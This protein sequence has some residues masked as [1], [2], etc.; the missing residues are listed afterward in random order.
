MQD[1]DFSIFWRNDVHAQGLFYDLLARS[2]RHAYD[3]DF[4]MQLAAYR[5]A[6][7]DAAHADIFAAQYLLANGDAEAA[8]VCGERAYHRRQLAPI[9]W[10]T[11]AATYKAQGRYV[12]A[13]IMQGYLSSCFNVP[14][15]LNL[16]REVLTQDVLDRLSVAMGKPSYAPIALFRMTYDKNRGLSS[17]ATAFVGEFLPVSPMYPHY[18]VGVYTEQELHGG[19]A[20]MIA[21]T[22]NLDG[23]AAHVS[24]DFLFDLMRGSR[25]HGSAHI[26]L[27]P[28]QEVVLPL[29]GTGEST[30]EIRIRAD[31]ADGTALLSTATPSFFRLS[32]TTDFSSPH[33]FIVGTPIAIGHA[34]HRRRLVLNLLV[35]ALPWEIMGTDFAAHMPYTARFFTK[36]LTFRQQF[37]TA[38][39]T[40]PSLAAIETGMYAQHSGVF[41]DR[42][43]MTL[44]PEFVTL[45]ERM[46]S[47]GYATTNLRGDG[48]GVYNGVTRGYDRLIVTPYRL[49]A[50]E[51]AEQV[52]RYLEG[53]PDADHFIYLHTQDLHPWPNKNFSIPSAAQAQLSLADRI[54]AS[55]EG[56]P[57]PYLS[58]SALNQAG[59][60]QS[61]RSVDRALGMLFTYLEEH[62]PPDEYLVNLYSDHGVSIF[63]ED[64][65]IVSAALTHTAWMMRGAGVPEGIAA[66]EMTSTVDIYPTLAHLLGFPVDATV[67]GVL[68]RIFGGPGREIACSNS[69]F[70][71]KPYFLAAR[72]ATRTLFLETE[73][74]VSMD[75]TVDLSKAAVTIY[76][77]EHEREKGYEIDDPSPRAFFYPRVRAFLK[78]IASNGEVFPP[79]KEA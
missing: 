27:S 43:V 5:K 71:T 12:D 19:K 51:G 34:P 76:P 7:G 18:Y 53:L 32:E 29:L 70:P 65:H 37:S 50:H 44:P 2:E 10:Q 28:Q 16:P 79:P 75:G 72:S 31:H 38:E 47:L 30:Q 15:D 4:L 33:D 61:V 40:Y 64:P 60:W 46:R 77:R 56:K 48:N 42:I 20:W 69:L 35:D 9:T 68:P 73:E 62:Y 54:D 6:G 36:G 58:P 21:A 78:G 17:S 45:S 55:A 63:D 39:F 22:R 26:D 25:A 11:L 49:P 67:D 41:N 3:D 52:I 59:F 14:I 13:L 74:P 23:F 8:A 57:S 24:G 66:D 1:D